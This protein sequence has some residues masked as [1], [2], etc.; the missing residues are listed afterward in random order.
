MM[1]LHDIYNLD[2]GAELTVLSACQTALGKDIRG[3]GFVGLNHAFMLAGSKTVIASLWKIDD[4]ATA[5]FM[6][7]FYHSMLRTGMSPSAALRSAKIKMARHERWGA[8][9]YWAGFILQGEYTNQIILPKKSARLFL[10]LLFFVPV[11]SAG[12]SIFTQNKDQ[13]SP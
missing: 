2:L 13:I 11:V 6:A 12:L 4:R 1:S 8:P 5:V 7:D 10:L 3:E 9:Y